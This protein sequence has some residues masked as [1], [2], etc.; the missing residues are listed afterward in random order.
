MRKKNW[1]FLPLLAL[2]S[3]M[4]AQTPNDSVPTAGD[5]DLESYVFSDY[6]IDDEAPNSQTMSSLANYND[7]I[8]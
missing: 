2:P 6:E 3:W 7:D 5:D 4:M 1:L 8:S